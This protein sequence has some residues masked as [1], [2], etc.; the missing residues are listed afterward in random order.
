MSRA[1]SEP[2]FS[3]PAT[4]LV[5]ASPDEADRIESSVRSD[6]LSVL[7]ASDGAAALRLLAAR[8]ID[9]ALIAASLVDGEGSELCRSIKDA[10]AT[11]SI[12]V[13]LLTDSDDAGARDRA[14]QAGAD[15]VASSPVDRGMVLALIDARLQLRRLQRQIADLEDLVVLLSRA[16]DDRD[17]TA[18]GQAERVAHWATQLG[19]GVGLSDTELT[20]L[21]RAALLHDLGMV[22]VP[23]SIV[24]KPG[25]LDAAE[26]SQVMRHP[27]EGE[28]LLRAIP[29][30]DRVL[31]AVRHH[32]ERVDGSGYPDGLVGDRIPLFARILAVA[33]AFVAITSDRPYRPRRS[34]AQALEVL[35]QGAGSQWER[36][37]VDRFAQILKEAERA[38]SELSSAG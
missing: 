15:D 17:G 38:P 28:R 12:P 19:S 27:E 26:F 11:R 18:G 25:P 7:T 13:I 14:R 31:P 29:D 37:L 16:V 4:V 21:Y 33:D 30:A 9:L 24:A 10:P 2:A 20:P 8:S 35:R 22:A 23:R 3:S 5:V 32:H 36:R 6:R 34:P 1:E